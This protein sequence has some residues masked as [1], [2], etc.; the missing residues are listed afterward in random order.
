MAVGEPGELLVKGPQVM[1][2]YWKN[3]EATQQTLQNGWLYTGDIAKMDED[4][5]LYIVGRKKEM[6]IAGGYNIYPAEIEE[7]LY[8]HPAVSEA[9]VYG[10]P[11]AYRGE[12]VKASIV[13]KPEMHATEAEIIE[14]CRERLA[15][16]KS[17]RFIDIRTELPKTAVGKLLRRALVEEEKRKLSHS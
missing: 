14:W 16:Y 7:V 13:L 12:T 10:I 3:P 4:G 11:D 1:K 5:F 6:I 15:A 9:I 17:P 2:G 8:E